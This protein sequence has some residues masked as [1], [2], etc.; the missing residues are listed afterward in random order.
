MVQTVLLREVR[1][2]CEACGH[3]QNEHETDYWFWGLCGACRREPKGGPCFPW[4][5]R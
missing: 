5:F 1:M 2:N 4:E 3:A